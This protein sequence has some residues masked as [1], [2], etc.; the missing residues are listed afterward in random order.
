MLP[1]T[2]M[3]FIPGNISGIGRRGLSGLKR[4]IGKETTNLNQFIKDVGLSERSKT[5]PYPPEIKDYQNMMK[6]RLMRIY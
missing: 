2:Q 5:Y 1:E 3:D 4:G 6:K